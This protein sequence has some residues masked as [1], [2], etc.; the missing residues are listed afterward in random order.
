MFIGNSYKIG[1]ENV[2]F[3]TFSR[4]YVFKYDK[5]DKDEM[6]FADPLKKG[7]FDTRFGFLETNSRV[8]GGM[9]FYIFQMFTIATYSMQR[10]QKTFSFFSNAFPIYFAFPRDGKEFSSKS[11]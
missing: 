7:K 9:F 3:A 4:L 10:K 11:G 8:L 6:C 1:N 5:T 2:H